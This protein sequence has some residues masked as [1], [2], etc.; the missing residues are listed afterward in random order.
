MKK[1]REREKSRGEGRRTEREEEKK[2]EVREAKGSERLKEV[3]KRERKKKQGRRENAERRGNG[4]GG[5]GD[6][7]TALVWAAVMSLSRRRAG[8]LVREWQCLRDCVRA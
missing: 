4:D 5:G 3:R 7:L 1:V 6:V 8:R 2:G